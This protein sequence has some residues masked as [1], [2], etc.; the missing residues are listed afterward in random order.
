MPKHKPT[1]GLGGST[2]DLR[3][4]AQALYDRA[5]AHLLSMREQSRHS[6]GHHV[7]GCAYRTASGGM[8]AVGC[9]IE[10]S[11]YTPD[12]EGKGVEGLRMDHLLPA[13]LMPHID[14]LAALQALHDSD[15]FWGS[16]GLTWGGRTRLDNI[17][18]H[19]GLVP[20]QKEN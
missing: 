14:L 1:T 11:E 4:A 10:D 9:L 12:M 17:A 19:H 2:Q 15:E 13:R 8:C 16:T 20:I 6:L 5:A 3:A 7:E 18:R